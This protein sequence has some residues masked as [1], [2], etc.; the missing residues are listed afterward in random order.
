MMSTNV[1]KSFIA[2]VTCSATRMTY[3]DQHPDADELKGSGHL[4]TTAH[5]YSRLNIMAPYYENG[6]NPVHIVAYFRCYDDY[7]NI[8]IRS[9]HYFGN[10]F[11]K[12]DDRILGAFPAAGGD[13][14][15]FNLYNSNS[16]LVTLDNLEGSHA[17][18][19]LRARNAGF[20]N[21]QLRED[22]YVYTYGDAPGDPVTFNLEILERNVDYP[23]SDVPYAQA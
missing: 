4:L 6:I 8:Q 3:F 14:T 1:E 20:I 7:Y 18:V 22:V 11:S 19:Y 12:N 10:F 13:T 16:E 21:R 17:T 2:R 9:S 23:T 15:S 5:A